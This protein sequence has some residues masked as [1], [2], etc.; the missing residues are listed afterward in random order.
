VFCVRKRWPLENIVIFFEIIE[1][2]WLKPMIPSHFTYPSL[3][4][5]LPPIERVSGKYRLH[6]A[7]NREELE[8]ALRLHYQVF[9]EEMGEG[10]E[11]STATGLD[12]DIYD[13]ACHHLV[14]TH[15]PSQDVIGT[16]RIQSQSMA[17]AHKGW[18]SDSEYHLEDMPEEVLRNAIEVGRACIHQ[19]H[20]NGRVLFLLW[21]GL[22]HYMK[23]IDARYLFGCCS[24]TTQNEEEGLV[25]M[26]QLE[27]AGHLHPSIRLKARDSYACHL[28]PDVIRIFP[29]VKM[30]QLMKIYLNYHAT[31]CSEPAVDRLFKTIDFLTLMDIRSMESS[32]YA[33]LFG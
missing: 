33:N 15:L 4:T 8:S 30:P 18:Y 22:A 31:I 9:N 32:M 24:L 21:K 12:E 6:L 1:T 13:Q 26:E 20:R 17:Q 7:Q 28:P 19:Q 29:E 5:P 14:I 10:L 3:V 23:A 2:T 11:S 27:A 25:M 16:Y